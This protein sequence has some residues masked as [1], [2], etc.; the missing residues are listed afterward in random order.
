MK[1][2]IEGREELILRHLACTVCHS[3]LTIAENQ[4]ACTACDSRGRLSNGVAVM[5]DVADISFFDDRHDVMSEAKHDSDTWSMFYEQQTKRI[6]ALIKPNS[7]VVDVGC[8]PTIPYTPPVDCVLIGV[9]ASYESIRANSLVDIPVFASSEALPLPDRSVD[10]VLCI[11]SIHHMTGKNLVENILK[12]S[13]AFREFSRVIKPGGNLVVV[14]LS[15]WWPGAILGNATWNL[16]RHLLGKKLDMYFW[17]GTALKRLGENFFKNA[18]L[19]IETFRQS[20][21][22]TFPPVFSLPSL[23]IP[24]IVYPFDVNL[25]RWEFPEDPS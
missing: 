2:K 22:T 16:A 3:S 17:R 10:L 12:V 11:Y 13:N 24:R 1:S 6:E 7:V 5:K 9:D 15:P 25:Y 14:D 19:H 18:T 20:P 8:G 21:L 4:I 23:K